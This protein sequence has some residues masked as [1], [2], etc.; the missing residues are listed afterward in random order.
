MI[1]SAHKEAIK[2]ITQRILETFGKEYLRAFKYVAIRDAKKARRKRDNPPEE[3]D[4]SIEV[5]GRK[6]PGSTPEN[7]LR[8]RNNKNRKEV[9]M[10]L[11]VK[12][13]SWTTFDD[14]I[15]PYVA[16]IVEASLGE[17]SSSVYRRFTHFRSLHKM[18]KKK[19]Q[20]PKKTVS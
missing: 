13:T 19:T 6:Y 14:D 1:T 3:V 2:D 15:D 12:I 16:F 4:S 9:E 7:P 11:K 8:P 20:R 10:E 5:E 18:A 17:L